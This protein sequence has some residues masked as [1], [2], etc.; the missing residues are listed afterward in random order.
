MKNKTYRWFCKSTGPLKK[1]ELHI[2]FKTY[3]NCI[4]KLK[5]QSKED[6]FK[7]YFENNKNTQKKFGSAS[8][9]S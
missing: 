2:K 1:N 8:G 9:T 4:V 6:Y 3:I 7:S 5:R